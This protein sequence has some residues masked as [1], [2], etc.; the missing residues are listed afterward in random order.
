MGEGASRYNTAAVRLPNDGREDCR[1]RAGGQPFTQSSSLFLH[2]VMPGIVVL[3]TLQPT[4]SLPQFITPRP[5]NPFFRLRL[6]DKTPLSQRQNMHLL[7]S[8]FLLSASHYYSFF[9]TCMA[10]CNTRITARHRYFFTQR[11]GL[12]YERHFSLHLVDL[13]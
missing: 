9:R 4:E 7:P 10:F 5:S 6:R 1:S 3:Y 11:R 2:A 12:G 13:D 8:C